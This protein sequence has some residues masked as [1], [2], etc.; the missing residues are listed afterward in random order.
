MG[1]K[2]NDAYSNKKFSRTA[3]FAII[4]IGGCVLLSP[5]FSIPAV[6]FAQIALLKNKKNKKFYGRETALIALILGY[7]I[8]GIFI[9]KITIILLEKPTH[10]K[11]I[12]K[13][14]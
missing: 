9:T 6:I 7:I 10:T 1:E 8:L 11:T 5:L 4:C 13:Y 2:M 14:Y 12:I 3:L